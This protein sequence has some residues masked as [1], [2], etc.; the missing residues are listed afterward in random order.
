MDLLK[1]LYLQYPEV[2]ITYKHLREE[3][4]LVI[5]PMDAQKDQDQLEII[6]NLNYDEIDRD[7]I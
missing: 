6:R 3:K 1:S 7:K 5:P 4:K 2:W